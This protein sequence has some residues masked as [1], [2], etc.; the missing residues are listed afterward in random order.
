MPTATITANDALMYRRACSASIAGLVIQLALVFATGAAA[1][2]S[3]SQAIYSATWHMLGGLP[4]WV[5]R[6]ILYQQHESERVQRLA[7]EKLAASE[8]ST[9]AIF[10]DVGD[11]LDAARGRLDRLYRYGL[12]AVSVI[13]ALYLVIAG[14]SLIFFYA[15][16]DVATADGA[17]ASRCDP[18]GLMFLMAAIAFA[19]SSHSSGG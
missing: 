17:L 18:V 10:G 8:H 14:G 6:V 11:D 12:P 4:I 19:N 16:R 13:T 15:R 1:L 2:W 9:A 7:A 3:D 5:I